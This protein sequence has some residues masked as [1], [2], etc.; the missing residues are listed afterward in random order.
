VGLKIRRNTK[1]AAEAV[2]SQGSKKKTREC[3]GS[4]L[5]VPH[6]EKVEQI[7][8]RIKNIPISELIFLAQKTEKIPNNDT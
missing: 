2:P 5:K 3:G 4:C 8:A 7:P 6:P 1:K